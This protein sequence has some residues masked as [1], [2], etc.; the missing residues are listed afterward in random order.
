MRY[1]PARGRKAGAVLAV[2]GRVLPGLYEIRKGAYGLSS[3][4]LHVCSMAGY[5][6]FLH[7]LLCRGRAE[8]DTQA[9]AVT[10]IDPPAATVTGIDSLLTVLSEL[11]FFPGLPGA[12]LALLF[13]GWGDLPPFSFLSACEF[14]GHFGIVLYVITSILEKALCPARRRAL[15]PVCFCLLYFVIMM[16]FDRATGMN[17]GFLLQ[18][19]PDSPLSWIE[20]VAGGGAGYYVLYALVVLGAMGICYAWVG[21]EEA[22]QP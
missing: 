15:I 1:F 19:A 4:P 6:C 13:P 17:Y 12:L 21:A 20:A 9:A 14:L 2:L 18:A 7:W 10:G 8:N 11:L 5:G 3:L 16:P 22:L